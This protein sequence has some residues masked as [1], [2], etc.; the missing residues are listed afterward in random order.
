V[1]SI[2]FFCSELDHSGKIHLVGERVTG[3]IERNP[4]VFDAQARPVKVA[5]EGIGRGNLLISN[6]DKG[7][8][9]GQFLSSG[10]L[11]ERVPL[12]LSVAI[13]RPQTIKK[14]IQLAATVGV[15]ELRFIKTDLGEKSYWKSKQ[16]RPEVVEQEIIKALEQAWDSE[17]L[18]WSIRESLSSLIGTG[19]V[20]STWCADTDGVETLAGGESEVPRRAGERQVSEAGVL[21]VLIGPEAGWS[22]RERDYLAAMNV[23]RIGLGPRILRV[24]TAASLLVGLLLEKL[25]K[26]TYVAKDNRDSC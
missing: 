3:I 13:P 15:K 23:K 4:W 1:N 8:L 24:E 21:Q 11:L 19:D 17:P 16:L 9:V 5:V 26:K 10:V 12:V 20:Y 18:K 25:G 6:V 7:L 22:Q 2:F 14:L